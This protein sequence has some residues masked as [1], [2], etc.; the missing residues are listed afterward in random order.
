MN[1][2]LMRMISGAVFCMASMFTVSSASAQ[3]DP[4]NM[5]YNFQATGQFSGMADGKFVYAISAVGRAPRVKENGIVGVA[6]DVEEED[7]KV[8]LSGANISFDAFDTSNPQNFP[9]I[10]NFSCKGCTLKFPDGSVLTSD[11]SVPLEG[12]ALFLYGPV[13]PSATSPI[14]SIRMAGCSGLRATPD[15]GGKLAGKVGTIC[16]NGEFNFDVSNLPQSMSSL[17]GV[18]NCTIVTHT[19][20]QH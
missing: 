15:S 12:R 4:V 13:A 11:P 5:L 8:L 16:F 20:M 17:T 6:K 2:N 10:V 3:T 18:S 1:N 19:P 7:Y 9:A 14:M